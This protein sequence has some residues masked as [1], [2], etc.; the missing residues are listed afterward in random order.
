MLWGVLSL[1]ALCLASC[2]KSETVTCSSGRVCPANM[3]CAPQSG[4][5]IAGNC[6]DGIRQEGER[7]DDGNTYD[8]DGCSANCLSLE[9]CGDNYLNKGEVVNADG[10]VIRFNEIC[11][12]GDSKSG[13]GCSADCLSTEVCGNKIVDVA[14]GEVCDDGNQDSRDGCRGDCKSTESCGN[15]VVDE[16]EQC[17]SRQREQCT[18]NCRFTGKCGNGVLETGEECDDGNAVNGDTC[19]ECQAARCGDGVVN[20]GEECDDMG[21]SAKCTMMCTFTRCGD[22]YLNRKAEG[23]KAEDCEPPG[24]LGCSSECKSLLAFCGNG[25]VE[26]WFPW[27]ETCDDGNKN[28]CGQCSVTC[29]EEQSAM[30]ST[31]R[32]KIVGEVSEIQDG[33]KFY[34]GDGYGPAKTFEFDVNGAVEDGSVSVN[35]KDD[36]DAGDVADSIRYAFENSGLKIQVTEVKGSTVELMHQEKTTL[37]NQLIS[38]QQEDGVGSHVQVNGMS[39]GRAGDCGKGMGC[40]QESDCLPLLTCQPGEAG[41]TCCDGSDCG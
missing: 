38:V 28:S 17:D 12:Y 26:P 39:G 9:I 18:A 24:S 7:C 27:L 6:G 23:D 32:I 19:S 4:T 16:G 33:W 25:D 8:G 37:G 22:N 31:G 36:E 40:M 35:V 13:D 11:D 1:S 10:G 34:V 20:P 21:D 30:A 2:Y 15:G 5:C 3:R 41:S 29:R 14:V